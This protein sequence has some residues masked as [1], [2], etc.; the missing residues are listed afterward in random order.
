MPNNTHFQTAHSYRTNS[1]PALEGDLGNLD[2]DDE[3][4]TVPQTR[5]QA[6]PPSPDHDAEGERREAR[7]IETRTMPRS[8]KI[9]SSAHKFQMGLVRGADHNEG[10]CLVTNLTSPAVQ[11]CH[12]VAQAT[13]AQMVRASGFHI[14]HLYSL[15]STC[16]SRNWSMF[17]G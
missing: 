4:E 10:C 12:L 3:G 6:A 14:R 13:D 8:K 9:T 15:N 1:L 7:G 5:P 2:V 16:R 11:S 17:G